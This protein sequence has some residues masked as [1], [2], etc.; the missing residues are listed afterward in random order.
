MPKIENDI[1][2]D[3]KDVLFKPKKSTVDLER[4]YTFRNSKR[5]YKGVPILAANMDTTGTFEMAIVF[6]KQKVFTCI[7]KHYSVDEW[8]L[9]AKENPSILEYVAVSVGMATGDLEKLKEILEKLPLQ[10]ICVDVAN[11]YS[12]HFVNFVKEVRKNYKNHVI[13]KIC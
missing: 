5:T 2:L 3:F 4:E 11:G 12:E 6:G 1:K 9:F 7:H 10:Y 13:M 8:V